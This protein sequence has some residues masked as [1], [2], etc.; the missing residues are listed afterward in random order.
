VARWLGLERPREPDPPVTLEISSLRHIQGEIVDYAVGQDSRASG[1]MVKDLSLPDG[2]VIALLARG[3]Q[4]IPP[5]GNTTIQPGDHVIL[6]L[7]PGVQPLVSQVF[8]R[9]S[10]V[11]GSIPSTLEF[12]LRATTTLGELQ[13]FYSIEVRGHPEWTLAE[14]IGSELKPERPGLGQV[15]RLGPLALRVLRLSGDGDVEMVGM[16]ILPDESGLLAEGKPPG[17]KKA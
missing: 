11:R 16:S 12:P 4:I 17:E 10:H 1:R 15:V 2:A 7:R 9:D 6:V 5:Q 8:G 3:N 14:T 13:E